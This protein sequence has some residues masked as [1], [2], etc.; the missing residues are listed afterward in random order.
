M[1]PLLSILSSNLGEAR[2]RELLLPITFIIVL[3]VILWEALSLLLPDRHKRA[4]L[5]SLLWL[6]FYGYGYAVDAARAWLHFDRML[7]P[8]QLAFA[9]IAAAL[10]LGVPVYWIIKTPRE[11]QTVTKILN[12]LSIGCIA[13]SSLALGYGL[14]QQHQYAVDRVGDGT[15]IDAAAGDPANYPDIYYLIFDAYARADYLEEAFDYD[16]G[17]FLSALRDRGFYIADRSRSNYMFTQMSLASSLNLAYLDETLAQTVSTD[18]DAA[19]AVL[20]KQIWDNGVVHFLHQRD[21]EFVTFASWVTAA[22]II[23]ADRFI[24]PDMPFMTNY[25]QMIIDQT[26][27]RSVMNRI[28]RRRKPFPVFFALD[29]IESLERND[30]PLFVFAH[31]LAPHL[32]HT[33][34]AQ[35]EPVNDPPYK[36]GY[37]GEVAYL[38][39]RALAVVDA[40]LARNP[41]T[42]FIIQGDHGPI[43]DWRLTGTIPADFDESDWPRYVRD[44]TAILNAYYFPDRAYAGLLYPEIT[45]VNS[46]RVLFNRTFG[47]SFDL[48]EDVS[49]VYT[50]DAAT[51]TRVTE[52]Y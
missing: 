9:V 42:V 45:P 50:R 44:R 12:S 3:C 49:Y 36:E 4:L 41:N 46:F 21:Y 20:A 26:P 14:F 37:R 17:P 23:A 22:E 2:P 32:P 35:G 6:P 39:Q 43:S 19:V 27:I 47:T 33:R 5:L 48:L 52:V 31:V 8:L 16:N 10:V 30:K 29:E 34:N 13:V 7:N 25:Q 18:W 28:K 11:F 51:Y 40:V 15:P 38:N 1:F 24:K